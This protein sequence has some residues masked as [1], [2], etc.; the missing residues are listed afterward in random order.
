VPPVH[1]TDIDR[2][3]APVTP[4]GLHGTI[5]V[6]GTFNFRDLGG[7]V[8]ADG[9]P[10][11]IGR[12]YRSAALDQLTDRGVEVIEQLG[13]RTV[14]DLRSQA[15]IDLH[16]RFPVDRVPVR[17]AHL[18]SRFGPPD[19]RDDP[20]LRGIFEHPDPMS[21]V[22]QLMVSD[23]SGLLADALQ[24]M[25]EADAAPLVFHCTSGKDRTGLLAALVQLISGLDLAAVLAD[26][27]HSAEAL[28]RSGQDLMARF[29]GMAEL[30]PE[31]AER[32]RAADPT[33]LLGAF[34]QIGGLSR[35]E[36]WL[37]SLGVDA[38][39]RSGVRRQLLPD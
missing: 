3:T 24:V 14:I 29:P 36:P 34:D 26:F 38:A 39:V 19:G 1:S 23:G 17:W 20:R 11:A 8:T 7:G 12:L 15:E 6:E 4:R 33:W 9:R 35:L 2:T 37:D 25:A 30:P 21:M 22:F 5:E 16:G 31:R 32:V 18:A 13:L 28:A 10:L 27:E